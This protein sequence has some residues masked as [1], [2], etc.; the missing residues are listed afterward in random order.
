MSDELLNNPQELTVFDYPLP[1]PA[2]DRKTRDSVFTDLF[3]RPKYALQL[4][5]VLHPEATNVTEKDITAVTLKNVFASG[6]YNDLGMIVGDRLIILVES[7]T[8]WNPNMALRCFFYIADTYQRY[9]SKNQID[10]FSKK[11]IK[12]P[13]PEFYVI[14]T[15]PLRTR[16]S[17]MPLSNHFIDC[18]EEFGGLFQDDSIPL[19]LNVKM[20]YNAEDG[21]ILKQ[22]FDYC[23]IFT[24]QIA[25]CHGDRMQAI[26]NTISICQDNDV[27][28]EYIREH[29]P[30]VENTMITCLQDDDYIMRIHMLNLEKDAIEKGL[31]EGRAEGRAEGMAKGRAEGLAEG[32]AEGIAEGLEKGRAEGIE[33]GRVETEA[34]YKVL[35]AEKE[36]LIASLLANQKG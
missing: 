11:M 2:A 24:Q 6:Q 1:E 28:A 36:A 25:A 26:K 8:D 4:F 23:W 27:L 15:G 5:K 35:L 12:L 14:Y 33:L 13:K 19:Q 21:N 16:E 10:L 3:H 32:R 18:S 22:Y 29:K 17:V 30:E 7:Q 20:L 9:I 31:A 34:K